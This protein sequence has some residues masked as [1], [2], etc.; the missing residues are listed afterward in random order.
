[1]ARFANKECFLARLELVRGISKNSALVVAVFCLATACS[2]QRRNDKD[3]QSN[4]LY[5]DAGS[6]GTATWVPSDETVFR[7][8]TDARLFSWRILRDRESRP[9]NEIEVFEVPIGVSFSE[10]QI[11]LDSFSTNKCDVA[12]DS[13]VIKDD[14][15][16]IKGI[17]YADYL[18]R[19]RPFIQVYGTAC[20]KYIAVQ[21]L[22]PKSDSERLPGVVPFTL[23][24]NVDKDSISRDQDL[25]MLYSPGPPYSFHPHG[26]Y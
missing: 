3:P 19:V 14:A 6:L 12:D 20:I 26:T 21:H 22:P 18:V 23:Y 11:C 2:T 7:A 4:V 24:F 5:F 13:V 25:P 9:D 15:F 8:I 16:T 10:K 17:A 1:M